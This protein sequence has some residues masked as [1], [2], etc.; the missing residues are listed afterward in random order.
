M[1]KIAQLEAA[2]A[3]GNASVTKQL[4]VLKMALEAKQKA[5]ANAKADA[6]NLRNMNNQ[7]KEVRQTMR[8]KVTFVQEEKT[9]LKDDL[10]Q[11]I[12]ELDQAVYKR[13][14]N[15]YSKIFVQIMDKV[16]KNSE[17]QSAGM[18]TTQAGE[19]NYARRVDSE[20]TAS[21]SNVNNNN[22]N[23]PII[24]MVNSK[25]RQSSDPDEGQNKVARNS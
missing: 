22:D 10:R 19:H 18:K 9:I 20:S 15:K 2:V 3:R 11:L 23:A 5:F 7:L 21:S 12:V 25:K 4:K 16:K 6:E 1:I 13:E 14:F 8:E 17:K 24:I